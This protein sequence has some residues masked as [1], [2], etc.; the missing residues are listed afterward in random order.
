MKA[1]FVK[2]SF[3]HPEVKGEFP[4]NLKK[5]STIKSEIARSILNNGF[6]TVAH[7]WDAKYSRNWVELFSELNTPNSFLNNLEELFDLKFMYDNPSSRTYGNEWEK[8]DFIEGIWDDMGD[9]AGLLDKELQRNK[10]LLKKL[11]EIANW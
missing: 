9:I 4:N 7:N 11:K 5:R 2:R 10:E 8:E 6:F 1:E 3:V